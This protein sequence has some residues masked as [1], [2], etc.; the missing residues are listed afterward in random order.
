VSPAIL[1]LA[2]IL[3]LALAVRLLPLLYC[4]GDGRVQFQEF[5][6][7]YHMRLITYAI[8]HFPATSI[9]DSYV[10]YPNGYFV[11]WPPLFDLAAAAA[12]LVVGL[13]SP[14]RFTAEIVSSA[15]PVV[16]GLLGILAAYFLV[17]DAMGEK[18]ALL[19]ALVMAILPA[20][21]F[22]TSFGYVDH[23]ALEMLLSV[24]MFLFFLR[25]ASRGKA[26]GLS[27]KNVPACRGP[28]TYAALA[29]VAIAAAVFAWD[30]APIF[31]GILLLY[32]LAQYAYD[33]YRKESSEYLT[34]TGLIASLV[35]LALVAPFAIT[36]Y[37]GQQMEISA[38]FLS[39]FQVIMLAAAAAFFLAMGLL[40]AGL[41]RQKAPWYALPA[42]AI[43][44]GGVLA[45]A[46]S[47]ALP[48]LASNLEAGV[49]FLLG[50][51]QVAGT[52]SEARSLFSD[53]GTFSL[54]TAW[55]F[56]TTAA[57]IAVPG[58]LLYLLEAGKRK[59]GSLDIFIILWTIVVTALTVMQ[60][61]F[62][63]LLGVNL[64]I[65]AGYGAARALGAA[66]L[67]RFIDTAFGEKG[68][69]RRRFR[70][71][72]ALA[73]VAAIVT[74]L[75]A[76]ALYYSYEISGKPMQQT[77]D[78]NE[79]ARWIS[80]NTPPTSHVYSAGL[81]TR[82]EYGVMTWWDY[83][84]F[85]LYSGERP[86]VA[87]N[88][89]TGIEDAANF[90]IAQNETA[91]DRIMEERNA[92]YVAADL[93]M[94]AL[95]AGI[96]GG[97]F[98]NIP[99]LAGENASTYFM[100]YRMLD[101]TVSGTSAYTDGNDKYYSTMYSRLFN[102]LG[103]GGRNRLGNITSGLEHYRLA[104][105]TRGLDPVVVFEKVP[106][107]VIRGSAAPGA[108]VKLAMNLSIG[109]K[110]VTY[111]SQAVADQSGAYRFTVPYATGETASFVKTAPAYTI[112]SGGG[113]AEVAVP[114]DAVAGGGAVDA[115]GLA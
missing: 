104:Y 109:D 110:T 33:A 79:A 111:F 38:I 7:Y 8:E 63:Y 103:C 12:S 42:A 25:G 36:G 27:L 74:L 101:P 88:F 113:R 114:A 11:G 17:R 91:A 68:K 22:R 45:A 34:V 55:I 37:H 77:S 56:V 3:A 86:A 97:I 47:V 14:D 75:L 52:I 50:S 64:A 30:G 96:P 78:W 18:A 58:F 108:K 59:P 92:R 26:Q 44:A 24:G 93:K 72:W 89:Q 6:P 70:A 69:A 2:G 13:G 51:G 76:P 60:A 66:G 19:A 57:L 9:Y 31:I 95:S 94:G 83:G 35:A 15:L 105:A 107:A 41:A 100:S 98:E 46:T 81:G 112:T 84:N 73:A 90:F 53:Y 67:E 61:R 49:A 48:Q 39:W 85:I 4:I 5:D 20:T 87:N 65:F 62:V 115:G 99:R 40:S 71:P 43:V 106:G 1:I 10:D 32:A 102:D 82:P 23:H 29:G 28:V 21:V 54:W 80:E 16:F